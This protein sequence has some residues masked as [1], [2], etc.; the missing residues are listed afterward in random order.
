M[1]SVYYRATA[2]GGWATRLLPTSFGCQSLIPGISDTTIE[3]N[4]T[5]R[6]RS[7]VSGSRC[8]RGRSRQD[9]T[10]VEA[11]STAALYYDTAG[12]NNPI[13][14]AALRKL[15]STSQIVFGTEFSFGRS[16]NITEGLEECGIFSADELRSIDRENAFKILPKFK[17]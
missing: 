13:Q 14:M 5:P 11:W 1:A 7:S 17:T 4:T 10:E 3:Y 8:Q 6:G 12:S 2:I 15:V 16:A 9:R